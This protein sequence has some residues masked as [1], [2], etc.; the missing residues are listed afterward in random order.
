MFDVFVSVTCEHDMD[1]CLDWTRVKV[2]GSPKTLSAS[3]SSQNYVG[4]DHFVLQYVGVDT[5]WTGWAFRRRID[6]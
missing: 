2:P 1:I 3:A 4:F 6:E 5:V